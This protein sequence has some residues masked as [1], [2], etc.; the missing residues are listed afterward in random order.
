MA[1]VGERNIAKAIE[2]VRQGV[3]QRKAALRWHVPQSTLS[4][5]INGTKPRGEYQKAAMRLSLDQENYLVNW[6]LYEER[7]GRGPSR[8]EITTF[9]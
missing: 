8:N 3:S 5:R 2:D 4:D 9:A 6:C 1:T 7:Y